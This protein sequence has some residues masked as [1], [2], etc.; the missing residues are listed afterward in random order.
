M[1]TGKGRKRGASVPASVPHRPHL[2]AWLKDLANA[3]AYLGAVLVEDDARGLMQALR[4]V[5]EA[6]SGVAAIAERT[7]LSRE[8]LYR[9]L[10][11]RGNPQLKNVAAILGATGLRLSETPALRR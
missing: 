6:R 10:S 8:A 2:L 1:T 11:K 5:A 9:M 4:D 3:S 7:G